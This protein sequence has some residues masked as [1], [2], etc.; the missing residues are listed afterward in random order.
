MRTMHYG[1]SIYLD[2]DLAGDVDAVD[3]EVAVKVEVRQYRGTGRVR[4]S[5]AAGAVEITGQ[6]ETVLALLDGLRAD[7]VRLIEESR[8][9]T[10][11]AGV[12]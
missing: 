9:V 4:I 1:V 6:P 3:D 8:H 2:D 10:D 12:A 11:Q 7:V 5:L